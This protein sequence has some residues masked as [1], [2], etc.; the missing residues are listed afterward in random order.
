[1]LRLDHLA[2]VAGDLETGVAA[3]E[4]ALGVMLA[5]GGKHPTMATHNRLLGLGDLYL[6]VIA[7]DPGTPRPNHP[8]WFRMDEFVGPPRL[9][10]WICASDDLDVTLQDAPFGAGIPV[11]LKRGDFA[12]RMAV[13]ADGRLP[14]DDAFPALMQWQGTAH[15]AGRLPDTGL[16][17]E[18][19]TIT[20]PDA[21]NLRAWL[22]R[23]MS[24]PR[25][26]VDAGSEKALS[27]RFSTPEG[28]RTLG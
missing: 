24:D 16:R 21:A 1:M 18:R 7:A 3:V 19:L 12:W 13:P 4:A 5:P 20:H 6:E 26:A 27:A 14:F 22:A 2:V 25:V 23:H 15:P 9:T 8:R 28:P 17:L 10:N 11:A